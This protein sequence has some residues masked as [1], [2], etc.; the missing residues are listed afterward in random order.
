MI[1]SLVKYHLQ[2]STSH[3]DTFWQADPDQAA[4]RAACSGSTLFAWVWKSDSGPDKPESLYN[5]H[6]GWSLA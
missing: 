5:Y 2:S 6:I 1:I 3:K 4:T